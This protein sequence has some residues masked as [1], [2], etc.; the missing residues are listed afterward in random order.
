MDYYYIAAQLVGIGAMCFNILSYTQ[1]SS[2]GVIGFQLV[3]NSLFTLS[4]LML[5]AFTGGFLN[6]VGILRATV[7]INRKRFRSDSPLWIVF[8]TLLYIISY[9]MTFAVFKT[10]FNFKNATVEFLPVIGMVLQT[11]AL[12]LETPARIRKLSLFYLPCW[13]TYN[14]LKFTIGGIICDSVSFG[15]SLVGI[16]KYDIKK[17]RTE[18]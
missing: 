11:V 8:F 6:A 3:G 1:K 16:V 12:R 2:K 18:S 4:Y 5:G 13:V 15:T 7:Y 17:E 14:I 9:V 10:D